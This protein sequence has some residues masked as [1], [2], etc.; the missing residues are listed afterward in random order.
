MTIAR[1]CRGRDRPRLFRQHRGQVR[2][3]L[4]HRRVVRTDEGRRSRAENERLA[5]LMQAAQLDTHPGE[6]LM[7][8]VAEHA[9]THNLEPTPELVVKVKQHIQ[10]T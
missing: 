4:F 6:E 5:Q 10:Q 3:H 2:H 8:K 7:Q 9:K 1:S